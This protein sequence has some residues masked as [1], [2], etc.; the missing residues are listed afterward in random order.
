MAT[1]VNPRTPT[2]K[3]TIEEQA[4]A[5]EEAAGAWRDEDYPDLEAEEAI[6]RWVAELRGPDRL[7]PLPDDLV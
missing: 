3:V 4:A 7:H 2:R 6:D 5:L 1:E